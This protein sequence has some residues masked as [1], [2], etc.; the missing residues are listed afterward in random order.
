MIVIAI[1]AI[2]A[3]VAWTTLGNSRKDVNFENACN[4]LA[5]SIN[6]ARGYALSGKNSLGNNAISISGLSNSYSILGMASPETS[7]LPKGV[8]VNAFNCRFAV[9]SG[10][11]SGCGTITFPGSTKTVTVE[12]FN[13]KCN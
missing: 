2:M 6:K 12:A 8:S 3:A 1:V 5:S 11:M 10:A 7:L 4:Q 13:A 9:P